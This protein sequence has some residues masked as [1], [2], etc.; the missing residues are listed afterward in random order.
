VDTPSLITLL[1]V[2]ALVTIMLSMGLQVE[3]EDVLASARPARLLV[4]GL[5][6]NYVLVPAVTL[7]LLYVFQANPMVSVGFFILAV[8]PGA[9]IGPPITAI[10]RGNVPWAIGMM[11][12]LAGLSAL[13]SPALLGVLLAQIAPESNL[14]INF[15]A[16][17][18][19][20]L[21]TQLLPLALGLGVHHVA[22]RLTQGIVKPV[23]L[24]ANAL[25]LALVGLI[26]AAQHE[27]LAAIRFRGWMGMSQ[28]SKLCRISLLICRPPRSYN[29]AGGQPWW[30][31]A[32]SSNGLRK[33]IP[34]PS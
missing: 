12:I 28:P 20:L 15:L 1:N 34:S 6:A 31:T 21:I 8:C 26:V 30:S 17:V 24:L 18:R 29:F 27:T 9:P 16:I 11:L 32:M 22:P 4:L 23:G 33:G 2:T 13:L 7:G 25:L 5:L 10:A 14:H 3:F 19:T